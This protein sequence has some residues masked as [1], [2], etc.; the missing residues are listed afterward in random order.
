MS[1]ISATKF[2]VLTRGRTGSTAIVDEINKHPDITCLQ[3][4]FISLDSDPMLKGLFDKHGVNFDR[5]SLQDWFPTFDLWSKKARVF[6]LLSKSIYFYEGRL[7]TT[8]KII[9]A[10]MQEMEG[11]VSGFG[12]EA[13]GFKLLGH[14]VPNLP[15]FLAVLKDRGYKVIYLERKN[16]VKQVLSGVIANKRKVYNQRNYVPDDKS[17]TIDLKEFKFLVSVEKSEVSKQ[18]S[19]IE[20]SE[21]ESLYVDYEDFLSDRKSFHTAIFNFLRVEDKVIEESDFSIMIPDIKDVVENYRELT[22]C[23]PAMGLLSMLKSDP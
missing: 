12:C 22:D 7:L 13:I 4:L 14:Q 21:V 15:A 17:F 1:E 6:K 2:V 16:V 10:Y 9:E 23:L 20:Y 5:Y 3:E 8:S 18:K 11:H 19:M